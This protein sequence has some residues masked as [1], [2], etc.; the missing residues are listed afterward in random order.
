MIPQSVI[1]A[2][3]AALDLPEFIGERVA[4]TKQGSTYS[5]LCPFHRETT[6]SFKVFADHYHC[7]G[8]GAHGNGIDFV[9]QTQGLTFP[10]AVRMLAYRTGVDFPVSKHNRVLSNHNAMALDVMR[11]A[12]A[13][14]QQLL[15]GPNGRPAMAALTERGIDY[16]TIIRFGIGFAPEAW[17]TLCDDRTFQRDALLEAGLAVPRKKKKGCY[18]FFR[19][20][21]LFPIRADN[22][23]VIGFGGRR[24]GEEGP[25]YLN[26]PETKLYR[27]GSVLFGLQ[28][29]RQAI[30][31][32]RSIIVCEGF[33]DVI[34]VSQ[35]QI[36]HIVS[37]CGTALT[38]TQAEIVLSL[39]DRVFFCFDGDTAGAKATWRAAE[40]LVPLVSDQHEIRLCRLPA[41]EDPDSFVRKF[42]APKFQEAL[43]ASP[44]LTAYLIGE[45][46][47]GAKL[48]EARAR[49]LSVAASLWRQF[50]APG[51]GIF[52][53][54][55]A[56]EALRLTSSEFDRIAASASRRD[57]ENALRNC[58]CCSGEASLISCDD[59]FQVQC[60]HCRITTPVTKTHDECRTIWNR[61]ERPR[62]RSTTTIKQ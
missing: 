62:M 1:D 53:R 13:K 32:T 27:K 8:C 35:A 46:T 30:R 37:T 6:P 17:S 38:E 25:K 23:N 7:Y 48:P 19:N 57:G 2:I 47:R 3:L 4:L 24:L 21:L 16:D 39:A 9:M 33:F 43:D 52:F 42:G 26:S 10:E 20:R 40:M 49:S 22:G 29:A 51:L 60:N 11:R 54:Q 56:C 18:D 14:Y 31:M 45:I 50:S 59:G 34:T 61:R 41:G 55:F 44:T 28:Q 36:E 5:G 15:L 12:C 58:P